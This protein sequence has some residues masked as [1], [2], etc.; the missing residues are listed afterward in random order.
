MPIK[1]L[2]LIH[3]ELGVIDQHSENVEGEKNNK[4]E[5]ELKMPYNE[6][7]EVEAPS[8]PQSL[9]TLGNIHIYFPL[10]IIYVYVLE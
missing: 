5:E 10:Y 9:P 3:E 2:E 7:A 6:D 8:I 1:Y 4:V